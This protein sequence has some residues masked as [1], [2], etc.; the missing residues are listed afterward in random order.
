MASQD[1]LTKDFYK[2]LGVPKDATEDQIKKAYRKL[3]RTHHPDKNPGDAAAESRFKDVGEAYAVLSDPEER[4]QYDAI[5]AMGAGG[6]RFSAGGAGGG[7]GFEDVFSSMFGGGGARTHTT[8]AGGFEDILSGMFGGG[9]G[10]SPFG[11]QGFGR[12]GYGRRPQKGADETASTSISLAQAVSGTTV[13][14]SNYGK[15]FTARIPAGV[16]DGQKIRLRGKGQPGEGGG[17][18]GDLILTISVEKHPVFELDGKNVKMTLPVSFS[19][20]ALGA[21]VQVPTVHGD[22]VTV[23]IPAGSSSGTT[24]RVRGRGVKG[25]GTP[26]DMLVTLKIVVPKKLSNEAKEAVEAFHQATGDADPRADF[27]RMAKVS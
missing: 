26:G 25:K 3:A 7:G 18:P 23:K 21:Q 17:E 9:G 27:A 4:K 8:G 6:A 14:V 2:V 13:Q 22:S 11:G 20:A 1:W 5:R 24:L 15:R 19:E 12:G 10:G 16:H